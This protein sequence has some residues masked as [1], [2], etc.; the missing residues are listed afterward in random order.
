[1]RHM[2]IGRFYS[3]YGDKE[4][5]FTDGFGNIAG[6]M[7]ALHRFEEGMKHLDGVSDFLFGKLIRFIA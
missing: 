2:K 7:C 6:V 4:N 5:I 3:A 1:M